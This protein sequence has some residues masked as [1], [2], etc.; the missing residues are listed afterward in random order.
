LSRTSTV[1][2]VIA[3]SIFLF[4]EFEDHRPRHFANA[5]R[6]IISASPAKSIPKRFEI[7]SVLASPQVSRQAALIVYRVTELILTRRINAAT[8][9]PINRLSPTSPDR[10]AAA[11]CERKTGARVLCCYT[12]TMLFINSWIS[13]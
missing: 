10:G 7:I 3:A 5:F 11:L 9:I 6:N 8:K 2:T 4:D 1:S 12:R 13:S